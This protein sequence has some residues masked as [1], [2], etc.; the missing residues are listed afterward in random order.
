MPLAGL[1]LNRVHGSGATQLTAERALAAAEE[2]EDY[3]AESVAE[4]AAQDDAAAAENLAAGGIVDHPAG[5]AD[6]RQDRPDGTGGTERLAAG[7]LR[8]HAERMQVV[9]RERRTRDRFVSVHPEVPM[10]DVTALPG[11][12][13]DLEG[14]RAIGQELAEGQPA[15]A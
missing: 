8:L 7:L 1:V 4:G 5:H 2:L 3:A 10:V 11:D 13:H 15:A 12:V 6:S 9:A 14:L